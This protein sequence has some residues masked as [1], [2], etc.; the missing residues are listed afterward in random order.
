[1]VC[2]S[3]QI[4][5]YMELEKVKS[6]TTWNDAA[7]SINSNNTKIATELT[8]LGKATYKNKGYFKTLGDLQSAFPTASPGS[9]AYVGSSYP[10]TI[11]M[12]NGDSWHTD[13]ETGGD[14]DV[15]LEDYY[16]KE[17]TH[18]AIKEEY[19]VLT[20]AE[21]DSIDTKEEKLYFCYEE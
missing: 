9:L 2:M 11:Y 7:Q 12:W 14:Q 3:D 4:I 15:N 6:D 5:E 21:Y 20:Q 13:G 8:K 16:T 17:E 1:M 19:V 10:F 18:T